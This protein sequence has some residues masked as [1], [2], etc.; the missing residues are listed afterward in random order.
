LLNSDT[1]RNKDMGDY[2][3]DGDAKG[4]ALLL[5]KGF[6]ANIQ[7]SN[8]YTAL[9]IAAMR[10]YKDCVT[11]LLDKGF[12]ANIQDSNGYTALMIAA[13]RGCKDC[14]S[15]LLDKGADVTIKDKDG[16]TAIKYLKADDVLEGP[17]F[18]PFILFQTALLLVQCKSPATVLNKMYKVP[19]GKS[20]SEILDI[21]Q[22]YLTDNDTSTL[23]HFLVF[24]HG[25]MLAT[26]SNLFEEAD[27]ADR[28]RQ[29]NSVIVELFKSESLD[30]VDHLL[31]LLMPHLDFDGY[32][33]KH[34]EVL[35]QLRY[36]YNA[37][38][39]YSQYHQDE[40]RMFITIN[41]AHC[42]KYPDSSCVLHYCLNNG[43]KFIFQFSQVS[44]IVASVFYSTIAP[45]ELRLKRPV[46]NYNNLYIYSA[47]NGYIEACLMFGYMS[48]KEKERC[49]QIF[50]MNKNGRYCPFYMFV[51][52]AISKLATIT[53]VGYL[54]VNYDSGYE[55][56]EAV[57]VILAIMIVGNI[58]YEVGQLQEIG[59]VFSAY[60]DS[61]NIL[62]LSSLLLLVL[63]GLL[64]LLAMYPEVEMIGRLCLYLSSIPLSLALLQ[65]FS[66]NKAV[67]QLIIMIIAMTS[68]LV[69]F[70]VVYVVCTVGFTMTL[71]SLSNVITAST[72][73]DDVN[74]SY[75]G[76]SSLWGS[77]LGL[78][79]ST[80]GGFDI[81][82]VESTQ[83]KTLFTVL[84]MIYLLA[85]S[86]QSTTYTT[87]HI[88]LILS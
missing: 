25:L 13:M 20:Q 11:L 43:L 62:D 34:S 41:A 4:I 56:V 55:S 61:W 42:I 28:S 71:T 17:F 37:E 63:W 33:N 15:L 14:V 2:A 44:G 24:S 8:G 69:S 64:A 3:Y 49:Y 5:D 75:G 40:Q 76:Y 66:V 52:E 6:D 87:T 58:V 78:Y 70:F 54:C 32:D 67:G 48:E 53:L 57:E 26:K 68:D 39:I 16:E 27:L 9:M 22:R 45:S 88:L 84:S 30:K 65:T 80:L 29:T 31:Q 74:Q 10:G 12:D 59:F 1:M 46:D 85:S 82:T 79:S 81:M 60:F 72:D 51:L 86:G 19:K 73:D 35:E 18:Y 23:Y 83:V 50:E 36:R 38:R 21:M 47:G 77:F 7:D